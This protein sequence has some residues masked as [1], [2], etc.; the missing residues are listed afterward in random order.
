MLSGG[1]AFVVMMQA[2]DF[3]NFDHRHLRRE[4]VSPSALR[5]VFGERQV[6]SPVMVIS[7]IGRERTMQRAFA[8]DDDMIQTLATNGPNQPFD[9]G[10]LPWRS[11]RR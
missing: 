2:T 7:K 10:A 1:P 4:F 6:S 9:I 3:A 8:E 11:R 5:C